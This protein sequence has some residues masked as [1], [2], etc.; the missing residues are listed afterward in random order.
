MSY[1]EIKVWRR[2]SSRSCVRYACFKALRTG[3]YCVQSADFFYLPVD[4][5]HHRYLDTQFLELFMEADPQERCTWFD[6][7]E[8]AIAA[9]DEEFA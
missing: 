2:L 4:E 8:A 3:K 9:H 7:L 5:Q 6:S 1:Q